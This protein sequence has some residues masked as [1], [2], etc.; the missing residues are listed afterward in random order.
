MELRAG[1]RYPTLQMVKQKP[2]G[3]GKGQL[4]EP[5][6]WWIVDLEFGLLSSGSPP[7]GA[8]DGAILFL[9]ALLR[10][11]Q[12]CDWVVR[13]VRIGKP[14]GRR[15]LEEERVAGGFWRLPGPRGHPRER[16]TSP[17][18]LFQSASRN[19]PPLGR[20][21]Q[22]ELTEDARIS[23]HTSPSRDPCKRL[24]P[25]QEAK[26]CR[27]LGVTHQPVPQDVFTCPCRCR[28]SGERFPP[29]ARDSGM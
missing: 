11:P 19:Q 22:P 7:L 20:A 16:G 8:F 4:S 5:K 29:R 18:Q 28:P 9:R 14:P 10:P 23:Q 24:R 15:A 26:P 12:L 3:V 6:S 21:V 13:V 25:D 2:R 1:Q 27:I 17:T